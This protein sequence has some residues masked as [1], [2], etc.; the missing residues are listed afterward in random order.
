LEPNGSPGRLSQ[1]PTR[2]SVLKGPEREALD[3]LYRV[4][5]AAL[6][7]YIRAR[8]GRGDFR[9]LRPDDTD[10]LLQDLFLRLGKTEWLRKPDPSR[11]RFRSY[12][13]NR[14]VFFLRERRAVAAR[15]L[16]SEVA[17]AP[18]PA[19]E[20]PLDERLQRDW[21]AA[22][23]HETLERIAKRNADWG[24]VLSADLARDDETNAQLAARLGRSLES[25][26]SL[27]KRARA[28]FREMY[29]L[30]DGRLDGFGGET[31]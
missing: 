13:V 30:V 23:V 18:E 10:D 9:P 25:F 7:N 2:W 1:I 16:I 6:R 15:K 29:P 31:F 5:G 20:D 17:E 24:K 4:Y 28:A 26:R 27:L 8:L 11:G 3:Y 21:K 22:T 12:L 19:M 14:L